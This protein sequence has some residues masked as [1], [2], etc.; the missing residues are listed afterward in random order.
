MKNL[1]RYITA[2]ACLVATID[3]L[4]K[5]QVGLDKSL[6]KRI[7]RILK[8]L[9]ACRVLINKELIEP[10]VKTLEVFRHKD[11]ARRI[12]PPS[13]ACGE[14]LRDHYFAQEAK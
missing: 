13:N 2:R 3:Y 14:E 11:E 10:E 12:E 8:E 6:Y 9:D 1:D 7:E 4:E 5:T